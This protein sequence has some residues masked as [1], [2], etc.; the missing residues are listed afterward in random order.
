MST[1][2]RAKT[3]TANGRTNERRV[4]G[5]RVGK[6]KRMCI[7]LAP[8]DSVGLGRHGS[9][10]RRRTGPRGRRTGAAR[11]PG[12]PWQP[13]ARNRARLS[14]PPPRF[15]SSRFLSSLCLASPRLASPRRVSSRES[16]ES[17]TEK[18]SSS[19]MNTRTDERTIGPFD[20]LRV[21]AFMKNKRKE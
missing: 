6:G 21:F 20:R 17:I 3:R 10:P 15:L 14:S 16:H 1:N 7:D 5:M 18:R 12:G 8:R 2:S 11:G 19:R 9:H 4:G 13:V